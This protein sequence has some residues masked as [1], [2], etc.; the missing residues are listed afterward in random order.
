MNTLKF[1][2]LTDGAILPSRGSDGACGLDIHS[3]EA[4][5]IGSGERKG[6]RTGLSV[7]IPDGC[8]GRIA[9]R[10]GLAIRHGIDTLAGVVDSDYRGELV[11]ILINLG[12]ML[13]EISPGD[14]IAQLIIEKYHR[15]E[16][17]WSDHLGTTTRNS[18][19]FG[20]TGI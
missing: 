15:L 8:Y 19:G 9:P 3:A 10:S 2:R 17:E 1:K 5:Q 14:R 13:F 18:G 20:S 12:E 6:V 4:V 16:P 7:A 11:C